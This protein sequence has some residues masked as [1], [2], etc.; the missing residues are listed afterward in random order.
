MGR[1]RTAPARKTGIIHRRIIMGL[2]D[3]V[4]GVLGGENGGN[5]NALL[6]VALEFINNQ[7]GG[8]NGLIEKFR[9]GGAGEIIGSWVGN[10]E[11]QPISPD[12]LHNVLGT[13]AI[14][15]IASKVGLDPAQ[16]SSILAQVLPHAVNHATPNGEVP[17]DGQVDTSSL[18]GTLSQLAGLFGSKPA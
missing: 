6:A 12:T 16:A 4:G 7:P 8:L 1:R 5:Q 11:N 13:D 17:A 10:G 14:T 3:I 18:L 9:Q 2:L 15:A